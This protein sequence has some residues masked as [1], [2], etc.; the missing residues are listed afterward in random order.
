MFILQQ[1]FDGELGFVLVKVQVNG[2]L[3][4]REGKRGSRSIQGKPL[5][6]RLKNTHVEGE[7]SLP[8]A[9]GRIET[10]RACWLIAVELLAAIYVYQFTPIMELTGT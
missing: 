3:L 9:P 2:P 8:P 1:L 6:A 5:A 7:K 4:E 10:L